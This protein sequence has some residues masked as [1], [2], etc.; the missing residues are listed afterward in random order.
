MKKTNSKS[1]EVSRALLV[2]TE[3]SRTP[4]VF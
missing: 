3:L 1:N 2:K 4:A